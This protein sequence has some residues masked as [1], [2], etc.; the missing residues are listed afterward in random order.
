[1][2]QLPG[3]GRASRKHIPRARM[4]LRIF[5]LPGFSLRMKSESR[6]TEHA[7]GRT[8]GRGRD[9]KPHLKSSSGAG[10]FHSR[11]N[12]WEQVRRCGAQHRRRQVA[13]V[14]HVKLGQ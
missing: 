14:T 4:S 12:I 13:A 5:Q 11:K 1:M 9:G 3:I 8:T 6:P 10:V 7:Q 2:G